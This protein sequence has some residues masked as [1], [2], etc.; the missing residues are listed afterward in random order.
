[1]AVRDL[2]KINR[3]TFFNPSAWIDYP[4]LKNNTLMLYGVLK[5][6]F[7][8]PKPT[9]S[10]TFEES[11]KRRGLSDKDIADGIGT[12]QGLAWVFVILAVAALVYAGYLMYYY[13]TITGMIL[14][15][16]VSALCLS[17][18]FKYDFWALQMRRR[19]LGLTFSDWKR[20]YLGD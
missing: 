4:S 18:A 13:S 6:T 9:T 16:V 1:M 12:Y 2:F 3:K 10:E 15:I 11:V 14:S 17:Q 5:N 7:T 19:K 20:Q 8:V